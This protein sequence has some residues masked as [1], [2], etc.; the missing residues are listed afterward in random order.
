M[1][2]MKGTALIKIVILT[3]VLVA[4]A[5]G[6][7]EDV[8]GPSS[9]TASG[10]AA[11][12]APTPL[13]NLQAIE[14]ARAYIKDTGIEDRTGDLTDP[15]NCPEI[16]E[17]TGGEFCIHQTASIYAPGLV[18]LVVGEVENPTETAWEVRLEP[19]ESGW[20]VS[21]ISPYGST[22]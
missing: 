8:A 7:D 14:A 21:E 2:I 16:T 22:E 4:A 13:P 20:K 3:S 10:P 17:E 1:I 9:P 11:S 15:L 5:C 19:S 12:A 6:G 18:I